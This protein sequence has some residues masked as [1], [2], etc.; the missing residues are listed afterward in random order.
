MKKKIGYKKNMVVI[1][2]DTKATISH[3]SQQNQTIKA[4]DQFI[5]K[6]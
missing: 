1:Q 6:D 4:I 2:G 5:K 3:K